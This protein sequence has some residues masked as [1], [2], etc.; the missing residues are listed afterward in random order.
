MAYH[1]L[2]H[3]LPERVVMLWCHLLSAFS[4]FLSAHEVWST[5][6]RQKSSPWN[7]HQTESNPITVTGSQ[8][9]CTPGLSCQP[10]PLKC[11][12]HSCENHSAN[13]A[14]RHKE[15]GCWQPKQINAPNHAPPSSKRQWHCQ[16]RRNNLSSHTASPLWSALSFKTWICNYLLIFWSLPCICW[17]GI[18]PLAGTCASVH[19]R[20][21][22]VICEAINGAIHPTMPLWLSL[23]KFLTESET[24]ISNKR[25]HT[26]NDGV[27]GSGEVLPEYRSV[28]KNPTLKNTLNQSL[29]LWSNMQ[30]TS[31]WGFLVSW[32]Q[33]GD[34]KFLGRQ[35]CKHQE[36]SRLI[37]I[38]PGYFAELQ[39]NGKFLC[40]FSLG[41]IKTHCSSGSG[42]KCR[43]SQLVRMRT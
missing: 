14:L 34:T 2:R 16:Q 33:K 22:M 32:F 37:S 6:L 15:K 17:L 20:M 4:Q 5:E 31:L 28:L 7:M 13:H 29:G 30:H 26:T 24:L 8:Q 35:M 12:R 11:Q 1:T 21:V 41:S 36:N 23:W 9:E 43:F 10:R 42:K 40:L 39:V 25:W 18:G 38:P 3:S 27:M 19:H